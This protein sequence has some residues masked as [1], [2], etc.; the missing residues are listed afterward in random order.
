MTAPSAVAALVEHTET[1]RSQYS[2]G[3]YPDFAG[4]P[5]ANALIVNE[6]LAF[7]LAV[8]FDE[9][10]AAELVW[11][12]PLTLKSALDSIS[13]AFSAEGIA[14]MGI[15][16]LVG[17]FK[18]TTPRLRFP[19]KFA[20]Y[21]LRMAQDLVADYEGNP[22]HLWADE[23]GAGELQK[24]FDRFYGIGQKKASMATNILARDLGAP[25]GDR[26]ALDVS[27]DKHVRQVF[28]RAGIVEDDSVASV[29]GA[30]R[31][32]HPSYPGELDLG[33]WDIGRRYCHNAEPKCGDC[34]LGA[35]CPKRTWLIA[36]SF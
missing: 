24:R 26:S 7:L 32:L 3:G 31:L 20:K 10:Q 6:P 28:L 30:A 21:A 11:R 35:I 17:V 4:D 14:S 1:A 27:G 36:S 8:L 18:A 29:V 23:P 33:A 22:E 19:S 15:A 25:I 9:G 12:Y 2:P 5:E 34:P 13:V 16:Q